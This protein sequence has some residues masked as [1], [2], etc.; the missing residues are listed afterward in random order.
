MIKIEIKDRG[1]NVIYSH[2]CENNTLRLTLEKAV[3]EAVDLRN[4]NL[5]GANLQGAFLRGALLCCADLEYARLE[6]ADLEHA[7]L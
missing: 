4:A 1:G 5:Q 7:D 6:G 3:K 2:E